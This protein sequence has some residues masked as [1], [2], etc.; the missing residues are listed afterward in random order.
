MWSL[1]PGV[2]KPADTLNG[3]TCAMQNSILAA[4]CVIRYI[5][6]VMEFRQPHVLISVR[7][8]LTYESSASVS[9]S[10][11]IKVRLFFELTF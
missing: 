11:P 3:D 1:I 6:D 4:L 5:A 10:T 2:I 8:S 9:M 7:G